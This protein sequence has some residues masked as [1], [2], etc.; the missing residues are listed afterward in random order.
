MNAKPA[1]EAG[2]DPSRNLLWMRFS[3]EVTAVH[4]QAAI[5]HVE[6]LLP[7]LREGFSAVTDLSAMDVMELE[8]APHIARMM[9]LMRER[10]IGKVVRFIPDPHK[11]IGLNILAATHY[12]GRVQIITCATAEEMERALA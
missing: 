7:Q 12:R 2:A 5:V 4:L 10:R 3:G 9:D 1:V 6:S 11:D 8:C